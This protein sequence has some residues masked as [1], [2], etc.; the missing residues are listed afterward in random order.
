MDWDVGEVDLAARNRVLS[1][2]DLKEIERRYWETE[3]PRAANAARNRWERIALS[4]LDGRV[5]PLDPTLR[6]YGVLFQVHAP[7]MR[8][9]VRLARNIERAR[10][11]IREAKL[12]PPPPEA[13]ARSEWPGI[14]GPGILG[15]GRDPH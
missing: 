1:S 12:T 15:K 11:Q 14:L 5:H 7:F 9:T 6:R 13:I 10:Q 3:R 8:D 2:D 4:L